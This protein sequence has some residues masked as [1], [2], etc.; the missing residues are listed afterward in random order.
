MLTE[1]DQMR[2]ALAISLED[3]KV[4]RQIRKDWEIAKK[5][6]KEEWCL[7]PPTTPTVDVRIPVFS[8]PSAVPSGCEQDFVSVLY[9]RN[10]RNSNLKRDCLYRT[11]LSKIECDQLVKKWK[12]ELQ[13]TSL[14][15]SEVSNGSM[16]Q[17]LEE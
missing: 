12:R 11:S 4:K 6:Q 5:I 10:S 7:S 2:I 8:S 13:L 17:L 1:E 14:S 9:V 16:P 15:M 3:A